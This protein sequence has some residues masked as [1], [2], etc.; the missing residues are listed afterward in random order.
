MKI[1]PLNRIWTLTIILSSLLIA[2]GIFEFFMAGDSFSERNISRAQTQSI[3]NAVNTFNDRRSSFTRSSQELA[4]QIRNALINESSEESIHSLMTARDQFWGASLF[5]ENELRI[6]TGFAGTFVPVYPNG[7]PNRQVL[8]VHRD[9]NVNF[10]RSH[11]PFYVEGVDSLIRYDL[12]TTF[13]LEQ[14]NILP[15]GETYE[16]RL[17]EMLALDDDYN[18]YIDF[19]DPIPPDAE[20]LTPVRVGQI[21]SAGFA[22]TLPG[23]RSDFIVKR[24]TQEN[25]IR[26]AFYFMIF[27]GLCLILFYLNRLS[28]QEISFWIQM[29]TVAISWIFFLLLREQ[30]PWQL[31]LPEISGSIDLTISILKLIITTILIIMGA[32]CFS[33][34][35]L[36]RDPPLYRVLFYQ[37]LGIGVQIYLI[38]FLSKEIITLFDGSTLPFLDLSL[39]PSTPTL[40]FYLCASV[41]LVV[42]LYFGYRIY[43]GILYTFRERSWQGWLI[44]ILF[45][46]ALFMLVNMITL[47][48]DLSDHFRW[49]IASIQLLM[50]IAGWIRSSFHEWFKDASRL[51]WMVISSMVLSVAIHYTAYEGY[52]DRRDRILLESAK[53][54]AREEESQAEDMVFNLL[55]DLEEE[56]SGQISSELSTGLNTFSGNFGQITR[57][58]IK[59]EWENYSISAQLVDNSGTIIAEYTSTLDSP[60]WTRAFDIRS[61]QIPIEMERI[62]EQ[63]LRPIIR[64][65]PVTEAASNYSAFRRG[66]I[67]LYDRSNNAEQVGWILCSVFREQPQYEKPLRSV[68][69]SQSEKEWDNTINMTLFREGLSSRS[70]IIGTPLELPGYVRLPRFIEFWLQSDS[71]I[72]RNAR[73]GERSVQEFFYRAGDTEVV[74]AATP[75]V[76]FQ[77]HIFSAVRL[78]F[79]LFIAGLINLIIVSLIKRQNII[80]QSKRFRDRLLD[81]FL[82][83]SLFCLM[84]L[85]FTS[86][87]AINRQNEKNVED[88]L[89]IKT[90]NLAEGL[91]SQERENPDATQTNL[92]RLSATLDADAS[93]FTDKILSFS[94]AVQIYEQH[95][96]PDLLPWNAHRRIYEQGNQEVINR[97]VLGDQELL[98]GY[99]PWFDEERQIMGVAGIPIFLKAPAFNEQF[100]SITSYL[101]MVY[102]IIFGFFIIVA[103]LISSRLTAPL[104]S[105]RSGLRKISSGDLETTLP[106]GS[107]DEIGSLTNAYNFM[108]GRLND[109]QKD[110]AE[111]E[112]EAAWKEM[113]QQVA[114]E[115]KNPLTPMKLNLQHL[116]QQLRKE[117]VEFSELKPRIQRVTENMIEQIESLSQIASDFSKFARPIQQ[118]FEELELHEI[119]R[120]VTELYE[121][122]EFL[123]INTRLHK[124]PLKVMGVKDELRRVLIN[125]IKNAREAMKEYGTITISTDIA[126]G[127]DKVYIEIEDTGEGIDPKVQPNIFVP[128]F[129]TKSSG[130]GL[131][132]AISKKIVEEHNGSISFSSTLGMGTTFI[133]MLPL[134]D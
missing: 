2:Y 96:I 108:V 54:F 43:F 92:D 13:R 60:S 18:I 99:S 124:A 57:Q 23:D 85:I 72:Y 31:F 17:E 1:F 114:H 77:N 3:N 78:F 64:S 35:K 36:Y 25:Q 110:L 100:L 9:N 116:E 107:K 55:T 70:T 88:Q 28:N 123:R 101:L 87:V 86:N 76:T 120:S 53:E 42:L 113:A 48:D 26:V 63:N 112:R 11:Y 69:A 22:Y 104:E 37:I 111:A 33:K 95:L 40:I 16:Y 45:G 52:S 109:V 121:Q 58:L 106:V 32:Y 41:S 134:V 119:V 128:N 59:P 49:I 7:L 27:G 117:D 30:I 51:R 133:I 19:F 50:I 89:L 90:K 65:Q 83:A 84:A 115:I 105:L 68:L 127:S 94:T 24:Q 131:G 80:D 44:I 8:S 98:I 75:T 66:W 4:V 79:F 91:S 67:P 56:L 82:I 122:D 10:L 46:P 126:A 81:R 12:I 74:R 15:I 129:S 62:R 102:V 118:D 34:D 6:W 61:L 93:L 130:T 5:R 21:D 20:N 125:V 71:L 14:T 103:S 73:F 39:I 132:L 47:F 29:L 38:F 97:A